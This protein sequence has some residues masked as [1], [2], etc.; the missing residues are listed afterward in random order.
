MPSLHM[1][2]MPR[3]PALLGILLPLPL[4]ASEPINVPSGQAVTLLEA[5]SNVPGNNGPALR[6]RFLAPAI[7]RE[8]GSIDADTA[9][10][11]MDHLCNTFA[12]KNLPA[13]DLKP[14]EIIISLSDRDVPLGEDDPEATQ[15]FN[16][17]KIEDGACQWEMF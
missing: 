5:V 12:L 4:W 17:Y 7:A 16:S 6:F 13:D 2:P 11:D 14:I 3:W 10:S 15:F 8:G 1:S 9:G